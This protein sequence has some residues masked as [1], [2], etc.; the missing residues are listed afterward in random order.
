MTVNDQRRWTTPADIVDILR[1]RWDSGALF[2]LFAPDQQWTPLS[3]PIRGP[4]AR[5]LVGD[6]A[7]VTAWTRNWVPSARRAWRLETRNVGGRHA[8]VNEI[9]ARVWFEEAEQLWT[10]LGVQPE[11]DRFTQLVQAAEIGAPRLVGWMRAHPMQVLGYGADWHS[12]VRTVRWIDENGRPGMYLRH[13]DVPGVDTKF[14]ETHRGTLAELL[15]LQLPQARID[16]QFP[17][18]DIEGRYGF[19]RKPAYVRFRPAALD[20][21][22]GTFAELSLR[23]DDFRVAAPACSRVFVVE[24]EVSYLTLPT[25]PDAIAIFGSG[26]ALSLL[27]AV[28]WLADRELVYWGDIDTHGFVILDRLRRH[29]PSARSILMDRETLLAHST[30]W[31][32][33][34]TPVAVPL[35]HL[36]EDEA[37]LYRDLV[38][39][40]FGPS[41]R[42]EQ[43]RIRFSAVDRAARAVGVS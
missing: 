18:R 40:T 7:A 23:A 19:Q 32:R 31:V 29:W 35:P 27:G 6:F 16:L 12:L 34:P 24:N 33:E 8:G 10:T 36:G 37:V 28:G 14:I 26:Y 4:S 25:S 42:L 15:D 2:S 11:V 9:P 38:E 20:P 21:R 3:V 30:Q 5:E 22:F 43:E 17:R 1:R 39:D 13:V 41:I